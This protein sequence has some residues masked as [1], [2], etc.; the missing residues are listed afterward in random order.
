MK[1]F[2][3]NILTVGRIVLTA[4]FLAMILYSPKIGQ[5]EGYMDKALLLFIITGLT[6]LV[7][8]A[9]ARKFN[10][11][12]KFGRM[13]DPLADKVLVCGAFICFAMIGEPKIFNLSRWV[14]ALIQWGTA[15]I[16][17]AREVYV[18][19]LRHIAEGRGVNFAATMSGKIKMFIQS[20]CIGAILVKM[21]HV[22]TVV[23]AYW[24]VAVTLAATIVITVISGVKATKRSGWKQA[25]ESK[26]V[27]GDC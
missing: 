19:V 11:A 2:I 17:I 8:G 7:D 27:C 3:P 24:F 6:D 23:W 13:M 10:V 26:A 1:R 21:G 12:S 5:K 18:T 9:I 14:L 22:Q 20:F 16:L 25:V 15:G 4:I